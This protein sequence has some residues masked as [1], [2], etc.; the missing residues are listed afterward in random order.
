MFSA[1]SKKK[2]SAEFSEHYD[3]K[4]VKRWVINK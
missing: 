2:K 3:V 1:L 4:I